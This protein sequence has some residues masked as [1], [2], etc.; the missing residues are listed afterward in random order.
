MNLDHYIMRNIVGAHSKV[1]IELLHL[2]TKSIP[3]NFFLASCRINYLHN[4]VNKPTNLL[5][6]RVFEAQQ[7]NPCKGDWCELVK[8]DMDMLNIDID[9]EAMCG[10]SKAQFKSLV[11]K[12]VISATFTSLKTI[13]LSHT[14]VRNIQY[15]S[16]VLQPYFQSE[17]FDHKE[18]SLLFNM[19]ANTINGFKM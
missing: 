6:R 1:P 3:L 17:L 8:E 2:E 4:I 9:E 5:I 14:K 16:F 12:H 13:Q 7:K 11:R 19:R 10:M 18:I 15:P